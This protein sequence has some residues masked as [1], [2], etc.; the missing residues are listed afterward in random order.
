MRFSSVFAL[1]CAAACSPA[2]P[3]PEVVKPITALADAGPSG[4]GFV[5][6]AKWALSFSNRWRSIAT[7][8]LDQ[9]NKLHAGDGGER[10]LESASGSNDGAST[11]AP[12]R[13]VGIQKAADAYRFVGASGT[14]YVAHDALGAL[15]KSGNPIEGARQVSVGKNAILVVD[16][17]GDLH[18]STDGGHA[19]SKVDLPQKEGIIVDVAMLGDKGILVAAPQRFYGT[20]DDGVSWTVVKSPGL[21]VQAVV[22]RDGAL[23]VDGVEDSMRF[24]PAWGTFQAGAG[25]SARS[26]H[27]PFVPKQIQPNVLNRIDGRRAIQVS[28]NAVERVWTVAV[29]DMAGLGKA[30]KLD[31]LDGCEMVDVAMRGDD[32]AISCDARGS[33]ASGIDKDATA[34][35]N[36]YGYGRSS[37]PPDGGTLGW[38]TRIIRS[39]D[40]GRTFREETT[41]EGGIPQRTDI[42][43]AL[44]AEDFVYL[45]RRCA[46][47]YNAPCL[48][49]RVRASRS[50]GFSELPGE[51]DNANSGQMR[52][53]MNAMQSATYSIGLRD[54]EAFLFRW[55]SG[56]AVPEPVGRIAQNIDATSATISLDDDG[57]VR[58]FVR[59]GANAFTFYYKEGGSVLATNLQIPLVRAAFAGIHGFAVTNVVS[60]IDAKAYETVDG[61]KTWG[62]VGSPAYVT[63]IDAC[64]AFGCVTDRGLRWGWD[65]PAGTADGASALTAAA[66]KPQYARPL[67]CSA[68]DKWVEL[69]GGNLPNVTYVD[70]AGARWV[71]PTR[72]KDGKIA[73]VMSKRGEA[74]TKTTSVSLLGVPPGPP[75]FGS[76]TTVHVQ[77]EGVVALRYVYARERKGNGRYNP[78]DA[79]LAWYRDA[80][81]KVFHA[82]ANKNPAFRVNKDPQNA[83]EREAQPAYSELPQIVALAPKGV[84]L[85][86]GTFFEEDDTGN[87]EPKKVP[88]LLLRDD[89]KTEKSSIP[90]SFENNS[91]TGLMA[92]LDGATTLLVRNPE[93]WQTVTLSDGKKTFYSVLG[94]LGDDDGVVDLM[95]LG[96]K[97][98]FAATMREPARAWVIGL[99]A[100]PDLGTVTAIATQKSL[101]DTPK[102][103][104]GGVTADPNT[105]RVDAPYVFGS[106][107]PVVVDSD[108]VAIVLATDR[109]EIRGTLGQA[110][111]CVA[112]FDAIV[113]SQDGDHDFGALIFADDLAHSLLF[114]A[115]SSTWPAPIAMRPMECQYQAGPLPDDLETVEGFVPDTRHAAVPHKRY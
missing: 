28:G 58:G 92:S 12:E 93:N 114:R 74:T 109:A 65:A 43:I 59:S 41:V 57:I 31:E 51:D 49:A 98:A 30:R 46:Q 54:G 27:R 42:A 8:D 102:P 80:T 115:D 34:P 18:R 3:T 71:L 2:N 37:G 13:I 89:G 47:G 88:L 50:A 24:D 73:L 5:T 66:H 107:R 95:S 81:G 70:H 87:A 103:C 94:G 23:W 20:K 25:S 104:D 78:V 7:I 29:G 113:P 40:G 105:Y 86:V 22:A 11:L 110:D 101:G 76:G 14:V 21:G 53:A 77:P 84:Y 82:T 69:G 44:G 90:E 1:A 9:G 36:R 63:T 62:L 60:P 38:I 35:I 83:Y 112:A 100:E 15:T 4:P 19:W 55:K 26:Q 97:P 108:G 16:G 45:G 52:F 61:G 79:Q 67:R 85:H 56:N 6:P 33:L 48:P 96:G 39:T 106:R 64:S 68:K 17:K 99:K 111:A 91:G 10:W 75:K 72:D 32:I